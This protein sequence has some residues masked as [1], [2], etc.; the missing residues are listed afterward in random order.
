MQLALDSQLLGQ[1]LQARHIRNLTT[2][3]V[4]RRMGV[5]QS[6]VLHF[7]SGRSAPTLALLDRYAHAV[8][9]LVSHDVQFLD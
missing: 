1:L 8:G 7:E 2:D 3:E 4:A 9:V 6:V 5:H